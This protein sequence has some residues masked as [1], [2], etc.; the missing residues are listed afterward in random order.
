MGT[1]CCRVVSRPG[2]YSLHRWVGLDDDNGVNATA[3]ALIYCVVCALR[4][5]L[6]WRLGFGDRRLTR[7]GADRE[8]YGLLPLPPTALALTILL[9][10]GRNRASV[11]GIGGVALSLVA[12]TLLWGVLAPLFG[13]SV[14]TTPSGGW[15][16]DGL[17]AADH[18]LG[19][20]VYV[21]HLFFPGG[22]DVYIQAVPAFDIYVIRG[23][24]A[25]GWYAVVFDKTVYIAVGLALIG[26]LVLCASTVVREHMAARARAWEIVFLAAVPACVFLAVEAV[27]AADTPRTS[28]AEMGRYLFPAAVALSAAGVS[29]CFG[30][31][32]RW[33]VPL[34]TVG[35]W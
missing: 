28:V 10:R 26:G 11:V 16:T 9:F 1:C 27:Y 3:G 5:G 33:A 8:R 35:V 2:Q 23:W 13:R 18:P 31:G 6:S 30:V 32:R 22:P 4:R 24:A 29:A 15:P 14:L 19:Y 21:W 20:L 34:A 7:S 25:F 12:G 17:W